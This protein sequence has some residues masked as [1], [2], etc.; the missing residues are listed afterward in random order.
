[1][2]IASPVTGIVARDL[3]KTYP[4]DVRALDGLSLTV[5]PGRGLRP[6]R[7]ERRRQVDHREDPHHPLATRLGSATVAGHDVLREPAATRR[8]IGS[9]SQRSAVDPEATGRENLA[10]QGRL[11]GMAGLGAGQRGSPSC[12]SAS[13]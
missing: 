1:M 12:S 10:L 7:P 11:Y 4:G 5:E 2:T 13:S 8:A 3:V 6:P 9:V